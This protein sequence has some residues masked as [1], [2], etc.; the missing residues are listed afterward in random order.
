MT[1]W[2]DFSRMTKQKW[3]EPGIVG[4]ITFFQ[5]GPLSFNLDK[6]WA[7]YKLFFNFPTLLLH[8]SHWEK[9]IEK[10]GDQIWDRTNQGYLMESIVTSTK[11]KYLVTLVLCNLQAEFKYL[12]HENYVIRILDPL[13]IL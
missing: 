4:P 3:D 8:F 7:R 2:F 5:L 1:D 9:I 6:I 12:C 11:I 13:R 10:Y